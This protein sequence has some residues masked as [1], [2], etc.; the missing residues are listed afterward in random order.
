MKFIQHIFS[1]RIFLLRALALSFLLLPFAASAQGVLAG[2]Q[3][4]TIQLEAQDDGYLTISGRNLTFSN[5]LTEV[6]LNGERVGGETLDEGMVV[7]Y[8]LNNDGVLARI[9]ILGP[10]NVIKVLEEN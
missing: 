1:S 8:T 3:T 9:E 6:Y 2:A 4:G 5:V 10:I 7:R